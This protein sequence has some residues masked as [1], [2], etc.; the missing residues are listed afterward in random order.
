MVITDFH[1]CNEI[2]Q[3]KDTNLKIILIGSDEQCWSV[4]ETR[5]YTDMMYTETTGRRARLSQSVQE[6]LLV[7][8]L[9]NDVR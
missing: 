2:S 6:F 5:K 7:L 8:K 4:I 1:V 3:K 9:Y